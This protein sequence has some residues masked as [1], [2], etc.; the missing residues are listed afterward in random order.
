MMSG[1]LSAAVTDLLTLANQTGQRPL[2]WLAGEYS[3]TQQAVLQVLT[4]AEQLSANAPGSVVW[5]S[6]A[7]GNK[8]HM[9]APLQ[10]ALNQQGV[11]FPIHRSHLLGTQSRVL[12]F[13]AHQG[14]DPDLF[15]LASGTLQSGGL[16]LL[17]AP[18]PESWQRTPDPDYRRMLVYP[19]ELADV[20]CRFMQ[21]IVGQW[22]DS[23]TGSDIVALW[24]IAKNRLAKSVAAYLPA[25]LPANNGLQT[26]DTLEA[27]GCCYTPDQQRI[28]HRV[29][30]LIIPHQI[31]EKTESQRPP[32][33]PPKAQLQ[34]PQQAPLVITADRGRGKSAAIGA[35]L[36]RLTEATDYAALN[37]PIN[38]WITSPHRDNVRVLFRHCAQSLFLETSEAE[39]GRLQ[40]KKL[41]LQY[42]APDEVVI[43]LEQG[44]AV[45]DLLVVDEAAGIPESMLR[46]FVE[47][48]PATIFSTTIHGYEGTGRGFQIR[49]Q[50]YLDKHFPHWQL[51][52]LSHP[53]RWGDQDRLEALLNKTFF[54]GAES[55]A[56]V[57]QVSQPVEVREL[58]QQALLEAPV[59][60][61]QLFSLLMLAHYRTSP[62][63]LRDLLDGLNLRVFAIQQES[64]VLGCCLVA[65]EGELP[66]A[67]VEQIYQ[68]RR[69]PRGHLL[70]QTLCQCLGNRQIP[71]LSTARVVRI[72][73]Q[74]Q[75]QG[76]GLGSRLLAG[77]E[78]QLTTDGVQALG[79]SFAAYENV[80]RF[81]QRNG[82][83]SLRL[84]FTREK[85]SGAHSLL[86]LKA[87]QP[88]TG[89]LV[90]ALATEFARSFAYLQKNEFRDLPHDTVAAIEA[91]FGA[92]YAAEPTESDARHSRTNQ[93]KAFVA[94][95]RTFEDSRYA[96]W[97]F[98][99]ETAYPIQDD[100]IEA[101]FSNHCKVA[102]MKKPPWQ[103]GKKQVIHELRKRFAKFEGLT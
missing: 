55:A 16:L 44:Q 26:S 57:H 22:L 93:V 38:V 68:G 2:L 94:G 42:L 102:D 77:V 71:L 97:C 12:I 30:E 65:M 66:Q 23:D 92:L 1:P 80:I 86:I 46:I 96:L 37:H 8:D 31:A 101:L 52:T 64:V 32:K 95:Y 60:L 81:W 48:S 63:D 51:L 54:L 7:F 78:H 18:E 69:R 33:T 70:P 76:Q 82:Y 89:S 34:Q 62:G 59:L 20:A 9:T 28:I 40:T 41:S 21:R 83:H 43:R 88:E 100:L 3:E 29:R 49:F 27:N 25:S 47:R 53:I 5:V 58:S 85:S 72:A 45:C 61:E 87:L 98:L 74:P 14:F 91:G 73:V 39:S 79:S 4:A 11:Y 67:L 10:Q 90:Q 17:L 75:C 99:Q 19:Y 50:P 84:G 35:A 24:L 13:D 6:R 56:P 36:A 103:M 15:C